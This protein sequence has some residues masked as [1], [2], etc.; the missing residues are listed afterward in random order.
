M[1]GGHVPHMHSFFAPVNKRK[2][3]IVRRHEVMALRAHD[4]R[5]PRRPH[6]RVHDHQMHRAGGEVR[7]SLRDRQRAI[8]HIE[9]LHGMGNINDFRVR[10]DLQ[11]DALDGA[12]KMI[13]DAK[14]G[15]QRNNRSMCHGP[16]LDK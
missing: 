3:A 10:V 13:A 1:L 6:S 8:Q 15:G 4:N 5:P 2:H 12:H 7:I 9:C 16:S 11:Y 14:I